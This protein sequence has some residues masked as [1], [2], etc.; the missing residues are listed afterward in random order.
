MLTP[1]PALISTKTTTSCTFL[2]LLLR[3]YTVNCIV[4]SLDLYFLVL[5]VQAT[6]TRLFFFLGKKY[7]DRD[8][9]AA[10]LVGVTLRLSSETGTNPVKPGEGHMASFHINIY[11]KTLF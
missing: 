10:G 7:L 5:Y 9:L 2:I 3:V 4:Y 6:I 8:I 1:P 11:L